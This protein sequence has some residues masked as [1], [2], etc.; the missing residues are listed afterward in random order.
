MPLMIFIPDMTYGRVTELFIRLLPA[1]KNAISTVTM[2]AIRRKPF[3]KPNNPPT[4]LLAQLKPAIL[5]ILPAVAPRIDADIM[6]AIK[7]RTKLIILAVP[8][9]ILFGIIFATETYSFKE[10]IYPATT[11]A[12]V[13]TCLIIPFHNPRAVVR[14][15]ILRIMMSSLLIVFSPFRFLFLSHLTQPH[16]YIMLS[17]GG[18]HIYLLVSGCSDKI[19]SHEKK[20]ATLQNYFLPFVISKGKADLFMRSPERMRRHTFLK[21]VYVSQGFRAGAVSSGSFDSCH[22][23][24]NQLKASRYFAVLTGMIGKESPKR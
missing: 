20:Q 2:I 3:R 8:D 11:P 21:E 18:L 23:C 13:T 19:I 6:Q 10:I 14:P 15:A 5:K 9:S 22:D 12:S 1:G 7:I 24:R 4:S 16:H 17:V